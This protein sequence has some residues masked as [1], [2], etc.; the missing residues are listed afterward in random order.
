MRY[1][2]LCSMDSSKMRG[3][4]Y[5]IVCITPMIVS[6]GRQLLFALAVLGFL[7]CAAEVQYTKPGGTQEELD[8][9]RYEC[10]SPRG[11]RMDRPMLDSNQLDRCLAAKGWRRAST[12]SRSAH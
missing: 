5:L 2:M 3:D 4:H 12:N 6:Q 7:G 10:I 8:W 9:D 1:G 11:A